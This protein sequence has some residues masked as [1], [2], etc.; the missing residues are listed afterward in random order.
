VGS[1]EILA[2][3]RWSGTKVLGLKEVGAGYIKPYIYL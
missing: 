2:G 1:L 3:I